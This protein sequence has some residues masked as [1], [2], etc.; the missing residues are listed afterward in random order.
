M[1]NTEKAILRFRNIVDWVDDLSPFVTEVMKV[2]D[3]LKESGQRS[4]IEIG[5]ENW[6]RPE[7]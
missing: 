2:F 5:L 4:E 6:L 7:G 3:E 1:T